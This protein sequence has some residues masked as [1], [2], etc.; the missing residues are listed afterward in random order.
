M[1]YAFPRAFPDGM[2]QIDRGLAT[3]PEVEDAGEP[4]VSDVAAS[5]AQMRIQ[6]DII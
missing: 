3:G 6:L 1:R 4:E 5:I 2:W